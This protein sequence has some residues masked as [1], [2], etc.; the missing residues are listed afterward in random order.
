MRNY[1]HFTDNKTKAQRAEPEAEI[2]V[3]LVYFENTLRRREGSVTGE[4]KEASRGAPAA[5][6]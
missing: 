5:G 4:G 2:L 3:H 6:A 1:L